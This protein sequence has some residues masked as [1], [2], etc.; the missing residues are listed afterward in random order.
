MH[1][2][3]CRIHQRYAGAGDGVRPHVGPAEPAIDGHA[4]GDIHRS[5]G[6]YAFV[7][8]R[9]WDPAAWGRLQAGLAR[10]LFCSG[11][12]ATAFNRAP[13]CAAPDIFTT[14]GAI[15]PCCG[16]RLLPNLVTQMAANS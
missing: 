12:A 4:F 9:G 1:G 3:I 13:R 7:I 6:R 15:S 2:F 5:C 14:L 10:R 16:T 8:T 11:D